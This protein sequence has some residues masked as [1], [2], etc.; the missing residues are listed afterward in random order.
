MQNF[1]H[2]HH[3]DRGWERKFHR[4]LQAIW[5][6][7]DA[8]LLAFSSYGWHAACWDLQTHHDDVV[9]GCLLS[10]VQLHACS[11]ACVLHVTLSCQQVNQVHVFILM[12]FMLG[13]RHFHQEP[14]LPNAG[15]KEKVGGGGGGGEGYNRD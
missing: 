12:Q 15:G 5:H 13:K 11:G 1:F 7:W 9:L 10:K 2:L 14:P 8:M 3:A 6:V 4:K